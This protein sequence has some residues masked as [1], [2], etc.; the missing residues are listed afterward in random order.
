MSRIDSQSD[1]HMDLVQQ[2][3]TTCELLKTYLYCTNS[4]KFVFL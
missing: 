3:D 2:L 1:C 4:T